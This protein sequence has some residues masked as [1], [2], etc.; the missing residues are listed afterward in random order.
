MTAEQTRNVPL[1]IW[2]HGTDG[3][4]AEKIR[5][6]GFRP[7]TYF[8]RHLEDALEFGD[9]HIFEVMFP[10]DVWSEAG[11]QMRWPEHR[12]P[13]SIVAY[14]VLEKTAVSDNPEL[15]KRIFESQEVPK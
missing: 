10:K 2:Y 4:A 8:S 7:H 12:G 6:D 3:E 13:E 5:R 1:V 15:R 11:W 14:Y 9:G